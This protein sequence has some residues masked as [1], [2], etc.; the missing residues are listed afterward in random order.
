M[1]S[2]KI[3]LQ[4]H[5]GAPCQPIVTTGD[6]VERG[7]LIAKPQGLGANLHAS[8]TG[9]VTAVTE[10]A[11][12]IEQIGEFDPS[13][14]QLPKSASKLEAIE[15]AGIVGA[16]GAGFPT[17]VKLATKIPGGYILAN[18]AEC[19]P[20]LSH[21]MEQMENFPETVI[22]GLI[23]CLDITEAKAA[24]I[25]IKPKNKKAMYALGKAAKKDPRIKL[26]YLSDM[27][28][29]GDERVI[30]R[31]I[32]G[33]T[34]EPGELP[35]KANAVVVNVETLKHITE[36]IDLGKPS[37]DKDITV[38]GRVVDEL[39]VFMN[40]PI[41]LPLKHFIDEAGGYIKPYGEILVGG[42]FTGR[43]GS[44]DTPVTKTT[45]G[46]LV[47]MPYPNDKR[48]VGIIIC[49][50]GAGR[51]RLHEIA[52]GMGAEVVSEQMCKRMVEVNGR[53]RCSL[54]GICPGQA[55]KVLAIKKDGAETVLA[56]TCQD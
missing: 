10:D 33:I 13:F 50:C 54:P 52:E 29:A 24:Y 16:G 56:G 1:T 44:E 6:A 11:I 3:S 19:E 41:G 4:Q 43:S 2:L 45:G 28:P 39:K 14:I 30:V 51:E 53:Y 8:V 7:Q 15:A 20:L 35:L 22:D 31:E 42:P 9:K 47:A 25:A 49:E 32:L 27:Y 5:V 36:A 23:H 21:N 40:Q 26:K 18:A 48:K 17:H 12:M 55:E 46:V 37:I 34:L 38:G